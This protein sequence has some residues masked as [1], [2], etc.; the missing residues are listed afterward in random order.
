MRDKEAIENERKNLI[1]NLEKQAKVVERLM[2]SERS[3]RD[4]LVRH[5][6]HFVAI[7]QLKLF[8][9][10]RDQ[11]VQVMQEVIDVHIASIQGLTTEKLDADTRSKADLR[12]AE[13]V[14]S[15]TTVSTRFLTFVSQ[16]LFEVD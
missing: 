11:S 15:S 1:R 9:N 3:L 7:F 6:T 8:Q 10:T 2:A 5:L 4:Q 14:R 16:D 12:K 13:D